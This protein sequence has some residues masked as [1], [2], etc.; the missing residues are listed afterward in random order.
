MNNP[1]GKPERYEQF[2]SKDE[3]RDID[4]MLMEGG[5][6]VHETTI[7]KQLRFER[8]ELDDLV[9]ISLMHSDRA[10]HPRYS[11]VILYTGPISDIS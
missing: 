9:L 1:I 6:V 4:S 10:H 8:T 2:S 11:S 5:I 3:M 7:P